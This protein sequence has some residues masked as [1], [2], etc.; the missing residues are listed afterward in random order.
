M[1]RRVSKIA[2]QYNRTFETPTGEAVLH[3]L[4]AQFYD[5]PRL[6]DS[7]PH[8]TVVRA[9]QRDVVQYILDLVDGRE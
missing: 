5:V 9:A 7:D 6:A 4:R 8:S 1:V 3:D 2:Q